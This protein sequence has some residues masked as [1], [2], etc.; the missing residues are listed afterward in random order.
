MPVTI[1]LDERAAGAESRRLLH[2]QCDALNDP[3][4]QGK[5]VTARKIGD[6]YS[7]IAFDSHEASDEFLKNL[8]GNERDII[9]R[10]ILVRGS[11][12]ILVIY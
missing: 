8:S 3:R 1:S 2:V 12:N 11:D 4:N 6:R 5:Y 7:P 10:P 9:P